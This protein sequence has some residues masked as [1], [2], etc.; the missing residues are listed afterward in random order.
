[1][2]LRL[3]QLISFSGFVRRDPDD[4]GRVHRDVRRVALPQDAEAAAHVRRRF[5]G[6]LREDQ[7][8][9]EEVKRRVV[10]NTMLSFNQIFTSCFVLTRVL[11]LKLKYYLQVWKYV[12]N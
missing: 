8:V 4:P 6:S 5:S 7:Q 10:T 1:M 11:S 3:L 2:S 12:F 9:G